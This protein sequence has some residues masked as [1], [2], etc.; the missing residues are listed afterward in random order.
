MKSCEVVEKLSQSDDGA[1]MS[2]DADAVHGFLLDFYSEKG[3][4]FSIHLQSEDD[5]TRSTP[6]APTEHRELDWWEK[7]QR[8]RKI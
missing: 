7:K 3:I 2:W 4:V 1:T 8:K 5:D 6:V